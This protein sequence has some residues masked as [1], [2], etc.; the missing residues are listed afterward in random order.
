MDYRPTG[1]Q[2][3]HHAKADLV[4][5]APLGA[6]VQVQLY[7]WRRSYSRYDKRYDNLSY[8]KWSW[9]IAQFY[10]AIAQTLRKVTSHVTKGNTVLISIKFII[11]KISMT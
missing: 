7:K 8:H 3:L 10:W 6:V 2:A 5:G 4:P 1:S 9:A 11:N